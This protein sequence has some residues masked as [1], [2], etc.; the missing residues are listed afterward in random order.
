MASAKSLVIAGSKT[1][2]VLLSKIRLDGDTQSRLSLDEDV[3]KEY[4]E[5]LKS[6][7]EFPPLVVVFDGADYWLVDGFHRR[8]A[9]V[10]QK[11]DKFKCQVIEGTREDARWLSYGVNKDHG[12]KRSTEDKQKA[13]IAALK[14]P[15]GAKLADSKIALHVG[16]DDKTVA[17]YRAKLELTSEIPK[18]TERTGKDGRTINTERIGKKDLPPLPP[19]EEA[20]IE[21]I[22]QKLAPKAKTA[23]L[24]ICQRCDT[25]YT[26][27]TTDCDCGDGPEV[28]TEPSPEPVQV[29]HSPKYYTNDKA[30]DEALYAVGMAMSERL[31][32]RGGK[33]FETAADALDA[34]VTA[35]NNWRDEQ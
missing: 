21:E 27:G 3:I 1:K 32:L 26:D 31:Q 28:E 4:G 23:T 9:A 25:Q 17:K 22:V 6:G 29:T 34:A 35:W 2:T 19:E 11:L 30:I 18:S 16:V 14:H 7:H 15:K 24:F 10:K 12:I 8:W 13:V 33:R 20:V 5:L